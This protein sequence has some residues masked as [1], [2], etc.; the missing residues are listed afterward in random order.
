MGDPAGALILCNCMGISFS[1]AGNDLSSFLTVYPLSATD[2]PA[3][4]L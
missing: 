4:N 1:E 2:D 3:G